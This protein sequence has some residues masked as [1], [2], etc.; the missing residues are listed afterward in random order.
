MMFAL[1]VGVNASQLNGSSFIYHS[2]TDPR[3]LCDIAALK[4]I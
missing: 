1:N 3:Y 4:F 2:D